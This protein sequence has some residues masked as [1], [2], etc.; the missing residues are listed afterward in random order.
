MKPRIRLRMW[1]LSFGVLPYMRNH[2]ILCLVCGMCM[3][4]YIC[5]SLRCEYLWSVWGSSLAK[6]P[7]IWTG[8]LLCVLELLF[9][10]SW[11]T[12]GVNCVIF[13]ESSLSARLKK[14]N[15][16]ELNA[17]FQECLSKKQITGG[18]C[19]DF[20]EVSIVNTKINITYDKNLSNNQQRVNKLSCILHVC[21]ETW[22]QWNN[23]T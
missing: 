16:T 17:H 22:S 8:L 14:K 13:L 4:A 3:Q 19:E 7:A 9:P 6:C 12:E 11:F 18:Q 2:L 10:Y 1:H 23:E 5:R 20:H 15:K 21:N